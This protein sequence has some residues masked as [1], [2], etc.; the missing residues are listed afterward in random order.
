MPKDA[1]VRA[2]TGEKLLLLLKGNKKLSHGP[3]NQFEHSPPEFRGSLSRVVGEAALPKPGAVSL[4]HC[5][6]QGS[7]KR[8]FFRFCR[9]FRVQSSQLRQIRTQRTDQRR[10]ELSGV[11]RN[12]FALNETLLHQTTPCDVPIIGARD[13]YIVAQPVREIKR[14][15]AIG[16]SVSSVPVEHYELG[17]SS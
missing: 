7:E 3:N 4:H 10:F 12:P 6:R 15:N 11:A 8:G 2:V 1:H 13:H 14:Y 9:P 16:I 17:E 5:P